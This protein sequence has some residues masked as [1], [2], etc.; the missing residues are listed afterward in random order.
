MITENGQWI[1]QGASP[2]D[3]ELIHNYAELE[4]YVDKVGFLPLFAGDITGFSAEE[5]SDARFWWSG[6]TE[7]DPW[8]WRVRAAQSRRIAYGKFFGGKAGFISTEWLP[9][10]ANYRR[11]GYDFD[12]LYEEGLAKNRARC[13]MELFE[14]R[15]RL[16][17]YEIKSL[18]GFGKGGL[19]NFSGIMTELQMKL[20]LVTT[21]FRRRVNKRGEEYGMPV[22]RY[23]RPEDVWGYELVSSAYTEEPADSFERIVSHVCKMYPEAEEAEI[24]TFLK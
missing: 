4:A 17:S 5:H 19:K 9:V 2:H 3:P 14:S 18:A 1:M 7:R 6:N 11:D 13:I 8:E 24:L 16:Y 22:A 23:E 12:S 15:D 10:F 21:D 20:Y